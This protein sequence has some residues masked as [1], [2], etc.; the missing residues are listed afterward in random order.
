MTGRQVDELHVAELG[1]LR[2]HRVAG[3]GQLDHLGARDRA[4]HQRGGRPQAGVVGEFHGLAQ[5]RPGLGHG[6]G[7]EALERLVAETVE[8]RLPAQLV[9]DEVH[10]HL[11]GEGRLNDDEHR[12]EVTDEASKAIRTQL[13]LDTIVEK[14]EVEVTQQELIE[15]LVMSA[16]QYGMDPAE[17]ARAIDEGNQVSGM[18]AEV[19]R[20]KALATVLERV[21]VTDAEGNAVDLNATIAT[22]EEG[23]DEVEEVEVT[24]TEAPEAA[25]DEAGDDAQDEKAD[26]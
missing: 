17:F 25:A 22:D 19:A 16:Q 11:E 3:V 24:E 10:A 1:D 18:A 15:Y 7:P 9:E 14:E 5:H 26:A 21:T 4:A 2:E 6:A 8:T 20:R 12:A 23:D 13:L